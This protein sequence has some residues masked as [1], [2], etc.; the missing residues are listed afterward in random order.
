MVKYLVAVD[1]SSNAKAAFYTALSLASRNI[2]AND[3]YILTIIDEID[4]HWQFSL[5]F[6]MVGDEVALDSI[7]KKMS[8]KAEQLLRSYGKL[9]LE[10]KVK[11][12]LLLGVANDYGEMICKTAKSKGI[13]FIIVGRRGMS[14]FKR[15][16]VG[17][18]SKHV[19]EYAPCNVVVVKGEWGPA[20]MHSNLA[21]V[22]KAEEEERQRRTEEDRKLEKKNLEGSKV[23]DVQ[24]LHTGDALADAVKELPIYKYA[25]SD[26]ILS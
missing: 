23:P 26:A 21:E 7:K 22:T 5:P 6:G 14:T 1:G 16:L 2:E 8:H 24:E 20:E 11:C 15:L 9:A 25:I 4:T 3:L 12:H 10:Q 17:S 13:D 19:T 18:N